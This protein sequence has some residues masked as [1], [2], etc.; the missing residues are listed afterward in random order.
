MDDITSKLWTIIPASIAALSV[1]VEIA[2]VKW[3]PLS[4]LAKWLGGKLN[5]STNIKIDTLAGRMDDFERE[6]QGFEGDM[7]IRRIKDL[8]YEVLSFA[9]SLR[10]GEN[11]GQKS[12]E[13]ILESHDEYV[14]LL[15]KRNI[16]NGVMDEA[17]SLI[18][19]E[20]K[21]CFRENSF[22]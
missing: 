4:S 22:E 18:V 14:T 6:L 8:R 1:F 15:S 7:D 12:F 10:R 21:Q 16:K 11:H 17:Y 3:C 13:H 2:P 5:A 9:D 19:D 20:Y